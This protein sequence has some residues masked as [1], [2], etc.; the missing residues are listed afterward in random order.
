MRP[1]DACRM[2]AD[3]ADRAEDETP[4]QAKRET[5]AP[6]SAHHRRPVLS[7]TRQIVSRGELARPASYPQA[8]RKVSNLLF[9]S[10]SD[11]ET[12]A[13]PARPA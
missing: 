7:V 12:G 5:I 3:H 1:G 9:V 8:E 2:E 13:V 11:A 6:E 10:F 4:D